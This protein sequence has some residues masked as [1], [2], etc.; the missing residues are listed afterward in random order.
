M[1]LTRDEAKQLGIV[2]LWPS[3]APEPCDDDRMNKLE[4]AFFERA[5]VRFGADVYFEPFKIRLAGRCW[6]TVDF[7]IKHDGWL[8]CYEVK[9]WMRDDAAVKL[10]V[11]A[12]KF[13]CFHFVLVTRPNRKGWI[14]RNVNSL[15]IAIGTWCPPWLE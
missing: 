15:G 7:V 14:C 11:A 6:Y 13:P 10:K 4:R 8:N 1:Q 2:H 9:G 3:K 12:E 5:Q